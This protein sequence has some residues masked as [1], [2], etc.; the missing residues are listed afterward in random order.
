MTRDKRSLKHA[1]SP[2]VGDYWQEHF[3]PQC[4]VLEANALNVLV[5]EEVKEVDDKHWTW[6]LNKLV[7]YTR[8]HFISR[9]RYGMMFNELF[10][11]TDD[12]T[13][14]DNQFWCDVIPKHHKC[15]AKVYAKAKESR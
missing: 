13:I 14:H 5:C 2:K 15:I 1:K 7:T 4:V 12:M 9:Y 10:V 6:D 3:C 8:G 11:G